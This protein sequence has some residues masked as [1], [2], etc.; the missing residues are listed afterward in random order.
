M[1]GHA[2]IFLLPLGAAVLAMM[3]SFGSRC[4]TWAFSR[5]SGGFPEP[6]RFF[7]A[8]M[9]AFTIYSSSLNYYYRLLELMILFG[10]ASRLMAKYRFTLGRSSRVYPFTNPEVTK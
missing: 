1:L 2:N 8:L 9:L 4:L 6:V 10:L 7:M 3:L 5:M